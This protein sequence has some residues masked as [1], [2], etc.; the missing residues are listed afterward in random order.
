MRGGKGSACD[1]QL[2]EGVA[3]PAQELAGGKVGHALGSDE[4][5]WYSCRQPILYQPL[6]RNG[7]ARA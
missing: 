2:W 3:E 5:A 1:G 6:H 7:H 4:N